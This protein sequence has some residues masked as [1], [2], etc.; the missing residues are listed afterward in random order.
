MQKFSYRIEKEFAIHFGPAGRL[1]NL[2]KQYPDTVATLNMGTRT[3]NLSQPMKVATLGVRKDDVVNVITEGP[4]EV[5]LADV[6]Y[7]YF[8]AAL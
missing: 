8:E 2:A 5:E 4:S 3:A 1:A 6:L 7:Q